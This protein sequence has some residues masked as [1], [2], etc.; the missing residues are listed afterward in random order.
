VISDALQFRTDSEKKPSYTG[1]LVSALRGQ[2]GHHPVL[3]NMKS[4]K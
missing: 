2:F 3:K 1:Q 4:K